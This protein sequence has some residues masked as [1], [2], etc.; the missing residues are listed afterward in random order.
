M[1]LA[2][3][4]SGCPSESLGQADATQSDKDELRW[5][6]AVGERDRRLA[7]Q[8]CATVGSPEYRPEATSQFPPWTAGQGLEVVSWNTYLGGGD[9]YRFLR[10]ELG[11][12]CASS[13]PTLAEGARPF[14]LLLQEVWRYDPGLPFVESSSVIPLT[15]DHGRE[16]EGGPSLITVAER[17]GLAFVYVPSA[18]NGPDTGTRPGVDKGNA[19]LS[20]LPLS[21]PVALD[22]PLEGGRKVAV[23]ATVRA[24]GGER[25]RMVSVH[26]DVASTLVRTLVT[27]N[28]T[29]ARQASGVIDGLEKAE[30]DGPPTAATLVGAD[31][32]SWV[33][34]ETALQ[35]MWRA[36]PESPAWDSLGTAMLG[37]P[38]DHVFFRRG[39]SVRLDGERYRRIE[40]RYGSDHHG[41]RFTLT[42]TPGASEN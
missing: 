28:Q 18:R 5:Y 29:R 27:G 19:V 31:M 23:G 20:T 1:E 22:L 35:L 24:P 36:F 21:S 11:L 6:R 33:G 3:P 39:R 10:N 15:T 37:L 30:R 32:N 16:V 17:C 41:R 7:A 4:I 42:Y 9:V 40:D 13:P 38:T 8:W 34:T 12:D 25:I 2:S 26:L 14:V